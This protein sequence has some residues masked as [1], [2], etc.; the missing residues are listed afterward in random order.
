[1]KDP[2]RHRQAHELLPELVVSHDDAKQLSG[3]GRELKSL[4]SS[5][6]SGGF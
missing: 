4:F 3:S 6:A 2:R 5:M 1:M